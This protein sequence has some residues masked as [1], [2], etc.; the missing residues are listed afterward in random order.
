MFKKVFY[1]MNLFIKR[2]FLLLV[3]FMAFSILVS[4]EKKQKEQETREALGRICSV[5]LYEYGTEDLYEKIF[6]RLNEI[7][8]Y[9]EKA[10]KEN[11][12]YSDIAELYENSDKP[13]IQEMNFS[14][15]IKGYAT[16]E[17][18]RIIEQNEIKKA[19]INIGG[20]V[21]IVGKKKDLSLWKIGIK[22][23]FNPDG[24]P[25]MQLTGLHDIA[26]VTNTASENIKKENFPKSDLLSV[27][28]I[29]KDAILADAFG[30]TILKYAANTKSFT[31]FNNELLKNLSSISKTYPEI[32]SFQFI[33]IEA[34]GKIYASKSLEGYL[35]LML[36]DYSIFFS[37]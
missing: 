31:K 8:K 35:S 25:A 17:V 24:F 27:T 37:I 16:E 21:Y 11:E 3:I 30:Q 6:N 28:V 34:N 33:L 26:I 5:N 1:N 7:S 10:E 4:C 15:A 13:Y 23:P 22:N 12:E 9:K 32:A 2:I 20:S 29:G 14:T 36:N 19:T 18:L